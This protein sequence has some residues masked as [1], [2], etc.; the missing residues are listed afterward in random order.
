MRAVS[1]GRSTATI[2]PIRLLQQ[3]EQGQV[4]SLEGWPTRMSAVTRHSSRA[5]PCTV[6]AAPEAEADAPPRMGAATPLM[7]VATS[8]ASAVR[9]R[10][11]GGLRKTLKVLASP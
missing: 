3:W 1:L 9:S 6:T 5:E 2:R 11:F 8:E 4:K 10:F 7:A